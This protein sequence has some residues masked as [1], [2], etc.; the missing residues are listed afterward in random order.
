[1][2]VSVDDPVLALAQPAA[3][4]DPGPVYEAL[5]QQP[6]YWYEPLQSWLVSRYEHAVEVIRDSARFAA[7]FRRV[8]EPMPETRVSVQSLD[9]P[10]QTAVRHLLVEGIRSIDY[11]ALTGTIEAHA[12]VLLAGLAARRDFDVVTD[13]AE[14]LA[15]D[16][17]TQVLDIPAPGLDWF[18]GVSDRMVDGMDAGVWPD[19]NEAAAAARSEFAGW[20]DDALRHANRDAATMRLPGEDPAVPAPVLANS[21]RVVLHAGYASTHKLL[22]LALVTLLRVPGGL[23]R[24]AHADPGQAVDEL[25]RYESPVRAI[26][27]ACVTDTELGGQPITAGQTVTVLVG[28]AN[29]DADRFEQPNQLLLDRSPNPHLGFGRGNHSCLGGPLAALQ[30]RVVFGV[31]A[32]TYPAARLVGQPEYRRNLTLRGIATARASLHG[33]ELNPADPTPT[34]RRA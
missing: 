24:F 17:I 32:R 10:E 9:P 19:L 31:L 15:L 22:G 4:R 18:R 11:A 26:A 33:H 29:R 1:M 16:T 13:F 28:A 3:L 27:R 21:L 23:T 30:A 12:Q 20:A 8:G 5:R 6:V 2:D 7:D 14:P 25:L 34:Q